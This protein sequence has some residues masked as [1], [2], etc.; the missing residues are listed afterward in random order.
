MGWVPLRRGYVQA[1]PG[2]GLHDEI[3]PMSTI[4][5]VT[6][7]MLLITVLA[8]ADMSVF[9]WRRYARR[10]REVSISRHLRHAI[11]EM[12]PFPEMPESSGMA[13]SHLSDCQPVG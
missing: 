5:I 11:D 8:A 4:T 2:N 9:F 10:R 3:E 7:V 12:G 6:I 1:F 13:E